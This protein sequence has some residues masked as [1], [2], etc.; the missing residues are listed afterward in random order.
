MGIPEQGTKEALSVG[1]GNRRSP[2]RPL[3]A[4]AVPGPAEGLCS[5]SRLVLQGEGCVLLPSVL[6]RRAWLHFGLG[7]QEVCAEA[8]CSA[9]QKWPY[10]LLI[11]LELFFQPLF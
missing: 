9:S 3:P 6:L 8:V 1:V 11:L 2:R 4:Q 7:G 10:I 5:L